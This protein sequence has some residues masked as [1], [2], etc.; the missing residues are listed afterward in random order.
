[1]V[2]ESGSA[3][4]CCI[5]YPPAFGMATKSLCH[6][7]PL[8]QSYYWCAYMASAGSPNRGSAPSQSMCC[9]V[10]GVR[11]WWRHAQ[12]FSESNGNARSHAGGPSVGQKQKNCRVW[13]VV[14][15]ALTRKLGVQA[16]GSSHGRMG[17]GP[18][19]GVKERTKELGEPGRTGVHKQAER[20][21]PQTVWGV[22]RVALASQAAHSASPPQP[23]CGVSWVGPAGTMGA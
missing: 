22:V 11:W 20:A 4:H 17:P 21:K 5:S 23:A 8:Q 1:M 13:F 9:T 19:W 12:H 6:P 3:A 7:C 16:G 15:P 10:M 2:S 18:G 14:V